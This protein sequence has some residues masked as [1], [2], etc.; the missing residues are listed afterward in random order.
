MCA[1]LATYA[2]AIFAF[3]MVLVAL[4]AI[5]PLAHTAAAALAVL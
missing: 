3:P 4:I 5:D 1:I 2:T